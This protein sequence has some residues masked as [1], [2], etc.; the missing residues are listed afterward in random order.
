MSQKTTF[1][2]KDETIIQVKE[3]VK[4]GFSKSMSSF[5]EIALNNE[6]E[7]IKKDGIRKRSLK[8]APIHYFYQ[9]SGKFR[10]ILNIQILSKL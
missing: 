1:I 6:L 4:A 10:K 7:K 5:V 9:I 2:I 8:Q 3:A